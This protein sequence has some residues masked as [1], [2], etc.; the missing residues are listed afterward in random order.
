MRRLLVTLALVVGACSQPAIYTEQ[1]HDALR[2]II[3]SRFASTIFESD[4]IAAVRRLVN[5]SRVDRD[6]AIDRWSALNGWT[7]RES[8]QAAAA[9]LVIT[10]WARLCPPDETQNQSP[11]C[12]DM[13]AATGTLDVIEGILDHPDAYDL[14]RYAAR[15]MTGRTND[16]PLIEIVERHPRATEILID[17]ARHRHNREWLSR[18][19]L[20]TGIP[21]DILVYLIGQYASPEAYWLSWAALADQPADDE[22]HR[23]AFSLLEMVI[24]QALLD[25]RM[26]DTALSHYD[27]VSAA[28]AVSDGSLMTV[29]DQVGNYDALG[30]NHAKIRMLTGL[31]ITA[32]ESGSRDVLDSVSW[33]LVQLQNI[34]ERTDAARQ[35]ANAV[36]CEAST[37]LAL[38]D[39]LESEQFTSADWFDRIESGDP[40]IA[41]CQPRPGDGAYPA[42]PIL[43]QSLPPDAQ[44]AIDQQLL[45]S[46]VVF[47]IREARDPCLGLAGIH[48]FAPVL[49]H[50]RYADRRFAEPLLEAIETCFQRYRQ[51]FEAHGEL[52]YSLPNNAPPIDEAALQFP[53]SHDVLEFVATSSLVILESCENGFESVA[54]NCRGYVT[55]LIE[56]PA[57][58]RWEIGIRN[59]FGQF[60]FL[61][62]RGDYGYEIRYDYFSLS[63]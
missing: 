46:G 49:R 62:A 2:Q 32:L 30:V 54:D 13:S 12:D 60:K 19:L 27:D 11:Q 34:R 48:S 61:I 25:A 8:E 55:S 35:A 59:D 4:D 58:D 33:H 28:F 50:P 9:M 51:D 47:H 16:A 40:S 29:Q 38:L 56:E 53:T 24:I 10:Q 7:P 31:A 37:A 36:R 44:Q 23:A 63:Y 20:R 26:T 45:A 41:S 42:W 22:L 52:P 14:L 18:L 57:T 3:G 39:A 15:M 6:Q 5:Y 17:A 43:S 21:S 1:D